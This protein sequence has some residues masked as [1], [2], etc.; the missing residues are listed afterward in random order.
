MQNKTSV[1]LPLAIY[2]RK[3]EKCQVFAA[4]ARVPISNVTMITTGTKHALACGNMTLTWRKWKRCLL[5]NHTWPNWKT[6]WT[7]AAKMCDINLMMAKDTAFGANQAAKVEQAQQMA[8][9]LDNLANATIPKNTTIKNLVAT[10]TM[11]T[12]ANADI[13]LSIARMCTAGVPIA[14]ATTSPAQL[15]EA[16]VRPSHWSNIKPAWDKVGYCWT[17]GYKVEVGQSSSSCFLHKTGHQPSATRA[18]IMSGSTYNTGYPT[19]ATPP[20]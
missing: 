18:N 15:M 8:S 9:S 4:N 17:H 13:Q 5:T 11:L 7:A 12:K 6:H 16:R 19:T 10:N 3:Q 14:Q 20:T 2:T 1:C